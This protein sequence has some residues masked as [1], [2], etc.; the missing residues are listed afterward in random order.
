MCLPMFLAIPLILAIPTLILWRLRKRT[1]AEGDD[2]SLDR[3]LRFV[4]EAFWPGVAL[5]A[6]T[7]VTRGRAHAYMYTQASHTR[8]TRPPRSLA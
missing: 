5:V 2:V 1:A 6:L 8:A 7:E 3:I 4:A